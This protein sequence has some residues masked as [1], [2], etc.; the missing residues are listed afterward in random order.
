[1]LCCAATVTNPCGLSEFCIKGFLSHLSTFAFGLSEDLLTEFES[2]PAK[3]L[4][5]Q[6]VMC[7]ATVFANLKPIDGLRCVTLISSPILAS[8]PNVTARS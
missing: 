7:G 1:M 4:Q 8:K 3:I 2:F 5:V 6:T